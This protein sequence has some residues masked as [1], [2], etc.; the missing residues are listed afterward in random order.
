[1]KFSFKSNKSYNFSF[2]GKFQDI[3]CNSLI[4]SV[5]WKIFFVL[6]K[7]QVMYFEIV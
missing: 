1:M 4:L 2:S 3:N 6:Q 7:L 5:G